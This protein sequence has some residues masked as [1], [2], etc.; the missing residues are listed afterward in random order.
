MSNIGAVD[1]V[2]ACLYTLYPKFDTQ[3]WEKTN[4]TKTTMSKQF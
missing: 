4:K 2:N 3:F 1:L